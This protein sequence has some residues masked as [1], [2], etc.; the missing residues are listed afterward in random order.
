MAIGHGLNAQCIMSLR[1]DQILGARLLEDT[2]VRPSQR[3][4]GKKTPVWEQACRTL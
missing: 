1:L 4:L 2:S 3:H